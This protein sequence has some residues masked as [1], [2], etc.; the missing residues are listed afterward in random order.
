MQFT[1]FQKLD[2]ERL[3]SPCYVVDEV[4]VERNLKVLAQL[5]E[6]SGA[7]I[8]SA[9]KAFS[10]WRLA[11]LVSRYL[12]GT[13]ASGLHEARLGRECYGGEVHVFSAGYTEG[14]LKEILDIADHVV[15]NSCGQWRRFRPLALE[16][17]TRRPG[18]KF[19]LR[20]NP[21]HSEGAYTNL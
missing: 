16:A 2:L 13:C 15:F 19:G 1:D 6:D 12:S 14:D 17:K 3:P 4:A 20:I 7:K 10:M 11:P 8:L 21:E 9:L 5:A 18:L